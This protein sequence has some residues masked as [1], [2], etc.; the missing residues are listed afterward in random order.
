[1]LPTLVQHGRGD[2]MIEIGRA[3]QSIETLRELKIPVQYREYDCG[4]EITAES[5]QDLSKF[6][7]ETVVSPILRA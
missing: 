3:R 6:L 5:L 4:H 7:M 2:D 1:M